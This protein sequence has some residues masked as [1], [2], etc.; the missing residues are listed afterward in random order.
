MSKARRRELSGL[1][2]VYDS[3]RCR[4]RSKKLSVS[5]IKFCQTAS[6]MSFC[7]ACLAVASTANASVIVDPRGIGASN[8]FPAT[9]ETNPNPVQILIGTLGG[10]GE[11]EVNANSTG[12]SFV[13]ISATAFGFQVG[14]SSSLGSGN[15]ILRVIGDGT[16]GSASATSATNIAVGIGGNGL[17][18]IFNGGLVS[19]RSVQIGSSDNI[20]GDIVVD[21]LYSRLEA[22][23]GDISFSGIAPGVGRSVVVSNG[24][25]ASAS[26]R[27]FG[28]SIDI[29]RGDMFTVTDAGSTADFE[30][31][32]F[33]DGALNVLNGGYIEQR[34]PLGLGEENA[35]VI[36][37]INHLTPGPASLVTISGFGSEIALARDARIG[38]IENVILD[39][40]GQIVKDENG[41]TVFVG[42]SGSMIVENAGIFRTAQDIFVSSNGTGGSGVL[43]V[44]DSG[45]VFANTLYVNGGGLLSGNGGTISSNVIVD[46]G[47]IAPGNSPGTMTIIGD[48][49]FGN[50]TDVLAIEIAGSNP[51]EF[52]SLNIIGN[53]IAESGFTLE[54]S[55]IDGFTPAAGDS[56]SFLNISGASMLD[57]AMINVMTQGL[58]NEFNLVFNFGDGGLAFDILP[59]QI[60]SEV[61]LPAAAWVFLAGL[62]GLSVARKRRNDR[63]VI[64]S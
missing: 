51:W 38:G 57:F 7:A 49:T 32:L 30:R 9:L 47:A 31:Q 25:T 53:L 15:G 46:G 40:N 64:A 58:S 13:S 18:E 36:G 35:L 29:N 42:T 34:A 12:N 17:V 4:A 41:N 56:F 60:P 6:I 48:L 27:Q 43:T 44:R 50:M 37:G 26:G 62:G 33:I 28:S 11:V 1:G 21:G 61:P 19:A 59:T 3:K 8:I 52:D 63:R 16:A 20:D 54:L 14:S 5:R 2:A 24:A 39:E 10:P 23:A 55:F 22:T 45:Q